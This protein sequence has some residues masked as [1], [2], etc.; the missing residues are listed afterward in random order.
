MW[1]ECVLANRPNAPALPTLPMTSV[2]TPEV[3]SNG[4]ESIRIKWGHY[5]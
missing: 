2:L 1:K 3:T 4:S 5:E